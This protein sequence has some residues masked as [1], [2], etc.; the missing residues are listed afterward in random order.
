MLIHESCLKQYKLIAQASE[1]ECKS[2][3]CNCKGY[4][5]IPDADRV[6]L[7]QRVDSRVERQQSDCNGLHWGL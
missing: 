5:S 7:T 3:C 4:S 2:V 1:P 6:E